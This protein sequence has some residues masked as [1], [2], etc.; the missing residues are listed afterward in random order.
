MHK[1]TI[2][3][4]EDNEI[5]QITYKRGFEGYEVLQATSVHQARDL[6]LLHERDIALI[7]LDGYMDRA[8]AETT[9]LQFARDVRKIGFQGPMIATSGYSD[10]NEQLM[11]AGCDHMA[12]K[13]EVFDLVKIH[14]ASLNKKVA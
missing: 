5:L 2:F 10:M 3:I 13:D 12:R 1:R 14:F 9:T 6:F 11:E 4:L 7:V 8:D